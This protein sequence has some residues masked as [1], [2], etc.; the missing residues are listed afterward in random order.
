VE[1]GCHGVFAGERLQILRGT[2]SRVDRPAPHYNPHTFCDFLT[3][4]ISAATSSSGGSSGSPIV[5][6]EG[7]AVALNCGGHRSAA[8]AMFLPL[9]RVQRALRALEG[10]SGVI[11]RGDSNV[12]YTLLSAA[13]AQHRGVP[14]RV[15]EAIA[16]ENPSGLVVTASYVLRSGMAAP[17]DLWAGDA[18][19]EWG[20]H[21]SL[22]GRPASVVADLA[23]RLE[24]VE[25]SAGDDPEHPTPS[26]STL[27]GDIDDLEHPIPAMY[28]LPGDIVVR[29]NGKICSSLIQLD[30]ACDEALERAI[31]TGAAPPVTRTLREL[32]ACEVDF[33]Q[34]SEEHHSACEALAA[35]GRELQMDPAMAQAF[36]SAW[37]P[38]A[39]SI[40]WS[41]ERVRSEP[42]P[43]GELPPPPGYITL[44]LWRLR[45]GKRQSS[46]TGQLVRVTLPVACAYSLQPRQL[47]HVGAAVI[48]TLP[49]SQCYSFGVPP[50]TVTLSHDGSIFAGA[51]GSG[52]RN[53]SRQMFRV[54]LTVDD[55]PIRS[56]ADAV[57]ALINMPN[58]RPIALGIGEISTCDS[59][60]MLVRYDMSRRHWPCR[61]LSLN[62]K[63]ALLD[64]LDAFQGWREFPLPQDDVV[65]APWMPLLWRAVSGPAHDARR[66]PGRAPAERASE[67]AIHRNRL[68]ASSACRLS[69]GVSLLARGIL[70]ADVA[71]LLRGV[72]AL[73]HMQPF[74]T[75]V[76]RT[77]ASHEYLTLE[78]V[79]ERA[80]VVRYL[81]RRL[82]INGSRTKYPTRVLSASL[83]LLEVSCR[84]ILPI[85]GISGARSSHR[86]PSLGVLVDKALG[87]I[88]I[89]SQEAPVMFCEVMVGLGRSKIP[90]RT[91]MVH[92]ELGWSLVQADIAVQPWADLVH[93]APLCP[94]GY[95]ATGK[96]LAGDSALFEERLSRVF[97]V[98]YFLHWVMGA[99][100]ITAYLSL[101]ITETVADYLSVFTLGAAASMGLI[102]PLA[103]RR[104]K[105]PCFVIGASG[106]NTS[107]RIYTNLPGS[108]PSR[109]TSDARPKY[110]MGPFVAKG[111]VTIEGVSLPGEVA[112]SIAS[113]V[114][115]DARGRVLG[116]ASQA[117]AKGFVITSDSIAQVLQQL[118]LRMGAKWLAPPYCAS[119]AGP[120][121]N[122]RTLDARLAIM[123]SRD[124]MS[125]VKLPDDVVTRLTEDVTA[126]GRSIMTVASASRDMGID[127]APPP[128]CSG[129]MLPG[130]EW[131]HLRDGDVLLDLLP[132]PAGVDDVQPSV[133]AGPSV[134]W[135]ASWW[136]GSTLS[137]SDWARA[138]SNWCVVKQSK[139]EI[140]ARDAAYRWLWKATTGDEPPPRHSII[141]PKQRTVWPITAGARLRLERYD[142]CP[143]API[144][145]RSWRELRSRALQ[146]P[147]LRFR[148]L[149]NGKERLL[150]VPTRPLQLGEASA[151]D[152]LCWAGLVMFNADTALRRLS[153]A[154]LVR[155]RHG[156]SVKV[157]CKLTCSLS[158][159]GSSGWR[160]LGGLPMCWIT[161]INGI[162]TPD[163]EA[164]VQAIS[165]V[166]D[167]QTARVEVVSTLQGTRSTRSV[168][169][170]EFTFPTQRMVHAAPNF[171]WVSIPIPDPDSPPPLVQVSSL[172]LGE[173][174]EES[175]LP[176]SPT[177]P[178]PHSAVLLTL[179]AGQYRLVRVNASSADE[180]SSKCRAAFLPPVV[181]LRQD[182][183]HVST[184]WLLSRNLDEAANEAISALK[185][186]GRKDPASF[187]P[188]AETAL[189]AERP[190]EE[191]LDTSLHSIVPGVFRATE[192]DIA[193]THNGD[194]PNDSNSAVLDALRAQL[195]THGP[196]KSQIARTIQGVGD[197][198]TTT[199]VFSQWMYLHVLLLK[200]AAKHP[201]VTEGA[202]AARKALFSMWYPIEQ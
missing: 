98:H 125:V 80:E 75:A 134:V 168:R 72:E 183:S 1:S 35:R 162:P 34:S 78:Q 137:T 62:V 17:S 54:L 102:P 141:G 60:P 140:E 123:S 3:E 90:G 163:V 100:P 190:M 133:D 86:N 33:V 7:S 105:S 106:S 179:Q 195:A 8:G 176:P 119:P 24:E 92:P 107:L 126:Y 49:L 149:R 91:I 193:P 87:L 142:P 198:L 59:S 182:T 128:G 144:P 194:P 121:M 110:A 4:Y 132:S 45:P 114:V 89:D 129:G 14:P 61:I 23:R 117:T 158:L 155:E 171:E 200:A 77:S 40:N 18:T 147:F 143:T 180:L 22:T 46:S 181:T 127:T 13:E 32:S 31:E 157:P 145:L 187:P 175:V 166:K 58:G 12:M 38:A 27:P 118:R 48:Q 15:L 189:P 172:R 111:T 185:E 70:M 159:P 5:N 113:G 96:S 25:V 136:G 196:S 199:F 47:F 74:R 64:T 202:E 165:R 44:D 153:T 11:P 66:P 103:K 95:P 108:L 36:A 21:A 146:A 55:E 71:D 160:A 50:G 16:K 112:D 99:N 122:L 84:P 131:G 10:G 41:V 124:A 197:T 79:Q 51:L 6:S 29:V 184:D 104:P 97:F 130:E 186:A 63:D 154:P 192:A 69:Q 109:F 20:A 68:L 94:Q 57:V 39:A 170:C 81:R 30:T 19:R 9:W 93:E 73:R 43:L 173:A 188:C 28:A 169:P 83:S 88:L 53:N 201:R 152:V 151:K 164:A 138:L 65:D 101:P 67:L 177:P 56:L 82:Q 76:A 161:A 148:L 85:E 150:R 52:G 115:F 2:I 167:R 116:I 135:A 191:E 178:A 26:M 42:A 37:D 174:Q 156:S 139:L 120:P